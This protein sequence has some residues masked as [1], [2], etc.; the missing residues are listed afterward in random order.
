MVGY[1][2]TLLQLHRLYNVKLCNDCERYI[3][4]DDVIVAY[5]RGYFLA[6]SLKYQGKPRKIFSRNDRSM[7]RDSNSRSPEYK[8]V[9]LI[10]QVITSLR[11]TRY[12]SNT[13]RRKA[14]HRFE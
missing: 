12:K 14:L 9:M 4:G 1:I 6:F 5:F 11:T 8:E 3:S 10:T 13:N 2:M 7:E